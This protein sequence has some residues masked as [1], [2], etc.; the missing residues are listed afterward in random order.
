MW[1]EK[2][3]EVSSSK[4]TNPESH[5]D[6]LWK[7]LGAE[8]DTSPQPFWSFEDKEQVPG[9][10]QFSCLQFLGDQLQQKCSQLFWGLPSL[11]SESLVATAWVARNSSYLQPLPV[12]FNGL[13]NDFA[14]PI[15]P[16]TPSG[17]SQAPPV[18]LAGAQ[19][20]PW[21]ENLPQSQPPPLAGI[22]TQTHVITSLPVQLPSSLHQTR[23][24]GGPCPASQNKGTSFIPTEVQHWE[25]PLLQKQRKRE[26]TFPSVTQRSQGL[27]SQPSPN[28]PQES[29]APQGPVSFFQRD[30]ISP[31]LQK[32]HL[33]E[34]LVK[35]AQPGGLHFK[36]QVSLEL[37][38]GQGQPPGLRQAP[39]EQGRGHLSASARKS[40]QDSRRTA[41]RHRRQ[42]HRKGRAGKFSCRSSQRCLRRTPE[43]LCRGSSTSALKVLG[44]NSKNKSERYWKPSKSGSETG[45]LSP[46]ES[47]PEKPLQARVGRK[48]GQIDQGSVPVSGGR[49]RPA[50]SHAFPGCRTD[51][52]PGAPASWKGWRRCVNTACALPFLSPHTRRLLEGHLSKLQARQRW[53]PPVQAREPTPLKPHEVQR[54]HL[55]QP[56]SPPSAVCASEVRSEA[57]CPKGL[58]KPPQVLSEETVITRESLGTPAAGVP[59]PSPDLEGIQEDSGET[60]P[61]PGHGLSGAP[62]S[63]EESRQ[64]PQPPTLSPVGKPPQAGTVTGVEKMSLEPTPRSAGAGNEPRQERGVQTSEEPCH[65]AAALETRGG[66]RSPRAQETR[67][68]A[69][70]E[71]PWE[72][73]VGPRVLASPQPSRA[74]G[75]PGPSQSPPPPAQWVAREPGAPS[76][77]AQEAGERGLQGEVGPENQPQGHATGLL[78]RDPHTDILLR[79]YATGMFLQDCASSVF[80]R[81]PHTDVPLAADILA[82]HGALCRSQR[83][84]LR[85]DLPAAQVPADPA[86]SAQSRQGPQELRLSTAKDPW[87]NQNKM[88]V[89]PDRRKDNR[90]PGNRKEGLAG[91]RTSAAGGLGH[92][93]QLRGLG[94]TLGRKCLQPLPE[95][96]QVFSESGSERMRRPAQGG[97]PEDPLPR[98]QPAW[99]AACSQ[100]PVRSRG[101]Q[102][103]GPVAVRA[104][105]TAVEQVLAQRLALRHG[106]HA[107]DVIQHIEQSPAPEGWR[108]RHHEAPSGPEQRAVMKDLS[109]SHQATPRGHT[110]SDKSGCPR[111]R[112]SRW[113]FPPREPG[114][115][116]RPCQQ[117]QQ[118]G[119][120]LA[121]G[122]SGGRWKGTY[123]G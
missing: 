2:E 45:L 70:A 109:Y 122:C 51:T 32:R 37:M 79:D 36:V 73:I 20:Q 41:S 22:Q 24:S 33:P 9:P 4:P 82:A 62:L 28:H 8:Q 10:Q 65:G 81:D 68:A 58:G 60:P 119:D 99:A 98:G 83:E 5:L 75:W 71:D 107:E 54:S 64:P 35:G 118:G 76:L 93:P 117:G 95:K 63:W 50:H 103:Q 120:S 94:D 19:P 26:K 113:A 47:H 97:G 66:P 69:G 110:F 13:S 123:R 43:G 17:L 56:P 114:A 12:L 46:P 85:R 3:E 57:G 101:A 31:D 38:P 15:Q 121:E 78:L 16:S 39:D 74:S 7:S 40:S 105:V 92:P 18:P 34:R 108:S 29:G 106:L 112:H 52:E 1:K 53:G 90:R 77:T 104:I 59:T 89:P 86:V 30:F 102:G 21:T 23:T 55:A 11:H 72:V 116:G 67:A 49:S 6:A 25:W 100:E 84:P 96:G 42:S 80:L 111:D 44:I 115:R 88:C 27:F 91:L 61:A 87:K 48:L 14:A